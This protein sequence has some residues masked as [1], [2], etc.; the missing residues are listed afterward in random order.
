MLQTNTEQAAYLESQVETDE[1]Q[2]HEE[3]EGAADEDQ[4]ETKAIITKVVLQVS[5]E[6]SPS[7]RSSG[8]GPFVP[9]HRGLD[10]IFYT[11]FFL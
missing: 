11:S 1:E 10:K 7:T 4:A 6:T 5:R 3:T 2:L 9:Q 8:S